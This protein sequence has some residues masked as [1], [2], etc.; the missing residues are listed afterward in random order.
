MIK[1]IRK[2]RKYLFI[3][4]MAL[5]LVIACLFTISTAAAA[6]KPTTLKVALLPIFDVLPYYVARD[7][8][9]LQ[10]DRFDIQAVSVGSAVQRD[11]LMQAG[12]IDGIINEI[13]SAA[14]FNRQKSRVKV[15]GV[16]RSS[17]KGFPLFRI[18]AAP[19]SKIAA[20]ADLAG[21]P[22]GVSNYTIIEYVTDRLLS[23]KGLAK[24]QIVKRSTPIIPER[25]QLLLQGQLKA[26]TLPDPL[27]FSAVSAG[28]AQILD[29]SDF[30]KYSTS[31]ITFTVEALE[32]KSEAVRL[33]LKGWDM[34]VEK[35]NA[36]PASY[37]GVLL[38]HIRVPKNV[39]ET[40]AIPPFPRARVPEKSQWV[41][42]MSWMMERGL[43][44]APLR[45]ED[46]V[47]TDFLP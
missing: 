26:A 25:Y 23:A 37:R 11:Q 47:T 4:R 31:T 41:D 1:N 36:N 7:A 21:V 2:P 39:R 13:I 18:L 43:L 8:G 42:V 19:G 46:S 29:D 35:I 45:Y 9:F 17:V 40:V 22:I 30:P 10:S 5:L 38:E 12:E 3:Q 6:S 16:A 14:N 32:N 44:D 28:A 33:F 15:V 24:D 27:A 20:P 34:A